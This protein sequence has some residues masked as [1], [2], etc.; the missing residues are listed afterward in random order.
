MWGAVN[1]SAK[2]STVPLFLKRRPSD[3]SSY[4]N[5]DI[6]RFWGEE[7]EG[8]LNLGMDM[9]ITQQVLLK[10]NARI[11]GENLKTP[12]RPTRCTCDTNVDYTEGTVNGS[13]TTYV[14]VC[15]TLFGKKY[16]KP[17]ESGKMYGNAHK[18]YRA[19]PRNGK[20]GLMSP[21]DTTETPQREKRGRQMAVMACKRTLY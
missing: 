7:E 20:R 4:K 2:R 8:G 10:A 12:S 15:H 11:A 6:K 13:W 3:I 19:H 21:I 18:E 9:A 14:K 17:E 16:G 1:E 5:V